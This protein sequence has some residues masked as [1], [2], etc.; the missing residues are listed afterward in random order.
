MELFTLGRGNY[1][2][3]DI[4]HAARAFTGWQFRGNGEFFFNER[5]HDA[6]NK[7]FFGKTGNF[8]GEDILQ[9]LLENKQTA[10]F[11][12]SKIYRYFVN[13][14]PDETIIAVLSEQF[15]RSGY[16]IAQLMKSIFTADWFYQPSAIGSRI[17]SPVELLVGM[18]Q[19]F[20]IQFQESQNQI[21]LQRVLGQLLLY[22]PSVAGW[23]EG[24]NWI[25]SSSL[26][27][28]MQLP[29]LIFRS[30]EVQMNTKE[31]G[32]VNTAGLARRRGRNIQATANWTAL[33]Q[34]FQHVKETD[35]L[36]V[37]ASYL[38]SYP[39]TLKQKDMIWRE[40][41]RSNREKFIQSLSVALISLPEYQLC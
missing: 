31:D 6:G 21:F 24:R 33:Q 16:D 19:T 25:D 37:L 36:D 9:M 32:D 30:A 3:K 34:A 41:D 28:R 2:E 13:D 38:L 11:I 12:T 23:K 39:I 7:T 18:Q 27:F 5:Q 29:E 26:L 40:A 14:T 22:P 4:R 8:T 1:T 17:K 20:G 35:T 15:Y 10:R